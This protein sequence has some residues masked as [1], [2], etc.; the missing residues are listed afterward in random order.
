MMG[1]GGR[2]GSKIRVSRIY[3]KVIIDYGIFPSILLFSCDVSLPG[4]DFNSSNYTT[5]A[6]IEFES[7]PFLDW[8]LES[9]I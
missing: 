4:V 3:P 8:G 7:R 2:G 9:K 1:V 5:P 6:A